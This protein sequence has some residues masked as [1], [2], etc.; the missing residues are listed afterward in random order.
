VIDDFTEY[1]DKKVIDALSELKKRDKRFYSN[2]KGW[3]PSCLPRNDFKILDEIHKERTQRLAFRDQLA[4]AMSAEE[5]LNFSQC[6][7]KSNFFSKWKKFQKWL[8]NECG[9]DEQ[10]IHLPKVVVN[11]L[12]HLAQVRLERIVKKALE[13]PNANL[14]KKRKESTF[15]GPVKVMPLTLSKAIEQVHNEVCEQE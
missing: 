3:F 8:K 6:Y 1:P 14:Q 5:Y 7:S 2:P 4:R 10:H 12:A 11:A 9:V 15:V 13:M